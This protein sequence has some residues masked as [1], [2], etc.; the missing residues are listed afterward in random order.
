MRSEQI[1]VAGSLSNMCAI[2]SAVAV[3]SGSHVHM[4]I[5]IA[6]HGM[7]AG[8]AFLVNI[9][10]SVSKGVPC[11]PELTGRGNYG[12]WVVHRPGKLHAKGASNRI[13]S[14]WRLPRMPWL[15]W[16]IL[17]NSV[18]LVIL[19]PVFQ[20]GLYPGISAFVMVRCPL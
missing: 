13:V 16:K 18:L 11:W 7:H 5:W 17:Q 12:A 10:L 14:I 1:F 2:C 15:V 4:A 9:C 8:T 3:A 20:D 19:R 6:V